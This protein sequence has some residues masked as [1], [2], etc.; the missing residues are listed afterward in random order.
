M[1][2][3]ELTDMTTI[4]SAQ[5]Q[6][7]EAA[8]K[9]LGNK[10]TL[11][12]I[13]IYAVEEFRGMTIDEVV[14]FIEGEPI[15]GKTPVEPGWTNVRQ[16]S[17]GQETE[18]VVFVGGPDSAVMRGVAEKSEDTVAGEGAASSAFQ[19][20]EEGRRITGMN[21]ENSEW[22]EGIIYFDVLFYVWMRGGLKQMIVNVEAQKDNPTG[23]NIINRAVFYVSRLVSSQKERE[24]VG[25]HFDDIKPVYSIWI[26]MNRQE[27]SLEHIHLSSDRL[28]G[29][30]NWKGNLDLINIVMIGLSKDLPE[31][32]EE[33][34]LHRLLGTMF[35]QHLTAGERVKIM[36]EEY[37]TSMEEEEREGVNIMCNLSQ[38]IKEEALAIGEAKGMAIGEAKGMALGEAKGMIKSIENV[39]KALKCSLEEACRIAG[40]SLNEYE[41]A[42]ELQK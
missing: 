35:S 28:L 40:A 10:K 34:R 19:G 12:C 29:N 22:N 18:S 23:Y 30:E 25:M 15:I 11:A 31:K 39:M 7:D 26:C 36:E 14:P 6:Y 8:K 21:T 2:E 41:A 27:N 3:T 5:I 1:L 37:M 33:L 13:L 9:L 20:K 16:T 4:S 24:F 42:K 38:G 17:P 32:K